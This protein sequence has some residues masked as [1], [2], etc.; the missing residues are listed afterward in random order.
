MGSLRV[1][2]KDIL[3]RRQNRAKNRVNLHFG[4]DRQKNRKND[5]GLSVDG[6]LAIY[7]PQNGKSRLSSMASGFPFHTL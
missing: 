5:S 6:I 2:A 3:Y 4:N 7:G 1:T